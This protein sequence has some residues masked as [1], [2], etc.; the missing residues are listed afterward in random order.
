MR[1]AALL[2]D[3]DGTLV[4]SEPLQ[5]AAYASYFASRGWDVADL[6]IFTG[7]RATDVF[8]VEPGPWAGEDPLVLHEAVVA[9]FPEDSLPD[10]VP[11][12]R[13][14]VLAA[15]GAAVPV[16]VVTSAG[17]QW[18]ARAV[19]ALGVLEHVALV[20]TAADVTDG[21]PHPAGYLLAAERLGVSPAGCLAAEDSPAGVRAAVSAGVGQVVG[22]TTTHDDA[23][24]AAAG[25]TEVLPDLRVLAARL[26]R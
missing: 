9:H 4:D 25:A 18:V 26:R 22:V 15:A 16:A 21:K 7:R 3:L 11:G 1:P 5:R 23:V 13:D 14:L 19:G 2:L 17:A 10:E 24:L 20:V 8:A 12:A 6:T